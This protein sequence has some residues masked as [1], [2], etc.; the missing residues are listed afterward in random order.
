[1]GLGPDDEPF[2]ERRLD[3]RARSVREDA[4]ELL[5]RLPGSAR[6]ARMADRL[7]P[8]LTTHGTLRK[9]LEVELPDDP[10]AAAVRDGLVDPGPGVSKRACWLEQIVAGAPLEVWTEVTRAERP[11]KV[12]AM[13]RARRRPACVAGALTARRGGPSRPRLGAAP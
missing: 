12:V 4:A 8:L 11:A 2:L 5:D 6:A 13:L 9:H 1:M 3:D 7:R 10:D